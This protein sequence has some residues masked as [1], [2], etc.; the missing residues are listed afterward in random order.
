MDDYLVA[1]LQEAM[2]SESQAMIRCLSAAEAAVED[3]RFNIAKVMRAAAHAARIRAMNL[4]RLLAAQTRPT[5]EVETEQKRQHAQDKAREG[6][7]AYARHHEPE[8]VITRLQRMHDAAQPLMDI[9]D[10]AA[11]SL[12]HHRDVMES[13]VDQSLWGCHDCGYMAEK[14]RPDIC[15]Q[16]GALGGEFEWFGP[17]YTTTDERLGRRRVEDIMAILDASPEAL[18]QALDG[19]SEEVLRRYPTPDEWCMKEIAGH[20]IDVTEVFLERLRIMLSSETP[21]SIRSP[22]PPWKILE[23]KGY[24]DTPVQDIVNRFRVVTQQALD[25]LRDLDHQDWLRQGLQRGKPCNL[26]DVGTWLANHNRAHLKQIEALREQF[27][28]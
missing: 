20:M 14:D 3:G 25:R 17:F 2:S 9:F 23:G 4:Q 8:D 10:R 18:T 13:D 6:I 21:Q 24:A 16:C 11:E 15:P 19:V 26:L 7:L 22:I 1:Q 12:R 27:S 28:A 5:I